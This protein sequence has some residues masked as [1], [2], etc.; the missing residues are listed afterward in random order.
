MPNIYLTI[1]LHNKDNGIVPWQYIGSDQ[2]D[3]STYF[4]SS[5]ALK[6]DISK[7]GTEKFTKII[8]EQFDMLPNKE[9]RKVEAKYLKEYNVKKDIT[10]YNKTD[11]YAPGGGILGMKHSKKFTRSQAWIDSKTGWDP[12]PRTR[13][14][15]T[16]QRSGRIDSV[17]TRT[18]KSLNSARNQLG[19]VG[20]Q[21]PT[22]GYKHSEEECLLRSIRAKQNNNTPEFKEL[23]SN[24]FSKKFQIIDKDG[25]IYYITGLS[26]WCKEH[27]LS[28]G[29]I[30]NAC[31][32]KKLYKGITVI[33]IE[34]N[35]NDTN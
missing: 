11:I 27:N 22:W 10:Y 23:I 9:L 12:S 7:L 6:E 19:K 21:S 26:K 24:Q 13:A 31:N 4:G 34:D 1:N 29:A 28:Y 8:I 14:I 5:H 16:A 35:I 15:W 2:F 17:E 20:I 25:S 32:R 30:W 33:R 3:R 18:K